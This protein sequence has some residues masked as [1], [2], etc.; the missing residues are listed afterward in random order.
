MSSTYKKL[1]SLMAYDAALTERTDDYYLRAKTVGS[2]SL[3]DLAREYAAQTN[4]NAD[5][6]YAI[7]NGLEQLKADA[8]ASGYIVSTPTALYQPA[9]SGTVLKADLSKP[10]DHDRV[11]V[12]ATV[13]QGQLLRETMQACRLEIFTQPAVVGPL[14]NG[15]VAETRAAD[16]TALTRAPEA[17]KNLTLTGR[18]IKVV[19][20]DPSVGV[21]FTNVETPSTT[22]K[23]GL[24]DITVNEPSRLI[25]VLP[26]QVTDGLWTVSVTT[27]YSSGGKQTKEARTFVLDTPLGV[28]SAYV[29]PGQG[30]GTVTP[31]GD[32]DEDSGQGTFG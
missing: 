16:G 18:N 7:I 3:Q 28:G 2:L 19:G 24:E 12:Y 32:D 8:V 26:A 29:D 31:G 4:R 30:S 1:I 25:F 27:Q 11:K 6:V 21:L 14:L 20:D 22:V 17:G 15:A 23:V 13:S 10:V 5:E 9:A